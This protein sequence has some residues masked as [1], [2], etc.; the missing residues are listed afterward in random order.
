[1]ALSDGIHPDIPW[2]EYE[3]IDRTNWSKLK[4][5]HYS[6]AHYRHEVL[7]KEADEDTDARKMGRVVSLACFEPER[8]RSRIAVWDG[9]RRAGRDWEAFV[10]RNKGLEL[11]TE[12]EYARCQAIQA[13]VRGNATAMKYLGRGVGEA[14]ML[15]K[16]LSPPMGAVAGYQVTCKAR[17]DWIAPNALVDLKCTRVK[18]PSNFARTVFHEDYRYHAQGAFYVDGFQRI[19]GDRRP[20][21]LIAVESQAPHVVQAYV[22]PELGLRLG[23]EHY[24]TLLDRLAHCRSTGDWGGY[25]DAELELEVP[26]WALPE[27]ER[28]DP[29][30]LGLVGLGK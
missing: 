9:G 30:G 7:N 27:E 5:M 8:F 26:H 13:A 3:R 10:E 1:M 21:V 22:L 17:V 16:H 20:Y 19:T 29:T 6:P 23:R 14:T 24:R 25:S 4:H 28:N 11:L 12:T 18:G 15:W 2:E